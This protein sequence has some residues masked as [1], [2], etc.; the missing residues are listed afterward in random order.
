[1]SLLWWARAG[2]RAP[3]NSK[4]ARDDDAVQIKVIIVPSTVVKPIRGAIEENFQQNAVKEA[5][6]GEGEKSQEGGSER[7]TF[8]GEAGRRAG[9]KAKR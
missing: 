4:T 9:A 8:C 2:G 1:M 3:Q 6:Q 7:V 5:Q